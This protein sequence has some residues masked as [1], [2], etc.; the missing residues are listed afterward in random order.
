MEFRYNIIWSNVSRYIHDIGGIMGL[1]ETTLELIALCY[2]AALAPEKW[3]TFMMRFANALHARS[4][5]LREVDYMAGDVRLFETVGYD[6]AWVVAYRQHFVQLDYFASAFTNMPIGALILGD[7]AIPWE[8]Q[9][10][11]EF[12]NDYILAQN[13]RHVMGCTLDRNDHYHLQF[14]LQRE[15]WQDN[16]DAD[17][18]QLIHLV[19]PH[20][21]RAVQIQHRM[22]ELDTEKQLTLAALDRLRVGVILLDERGMPKHLNREAERLASGCNGLTVRRDGLALAAATDNNRLRHLIADAAALANG[23]A[24]TAGGCLRVVRQNGS[25]QIQVVPLPKGLSKRPLEQ[26]LPAGCVAVFV[27]TAGGVCLPWERVAAMHGLTRA[28]ARLAALLAKGISLEE[29]AETLSI[30]VQTARSQLKAVFGKTGVSRQAELVALLLADMLS[31]Q[32]NDP[33]EP[34]P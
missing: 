16:F 15:Q 12:C 8:Q 20:M 3:Q 29:I 1:E 27:S 14:G 24:A 22:T 6:P 30:S 25:L 2:D 9:R 13:V 32:T 4:A 31:Y 23:R 10:K 26:S 17:A 18:R 28:E 34:A 19:A 21:T 5:M 11:T 7:Q 33:L